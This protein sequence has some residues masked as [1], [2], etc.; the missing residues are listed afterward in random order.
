MSKYKN[1]EGAALI[2]TMF[3]ITILLLFVSA[4]LFQVT[5]TRKQVNTME[6]SIM[7]GHMA[8]MG[9]DYYRSF[10]KNIEQD[11]SEPL[12]K[13]VANLKSA[14][15]KEIKQLVSSSSNGDDRSY[16]IITDN[17]DTEV[18]DNEI[19]IEFTSIGKAYD[20]EKKIESTITISVIEN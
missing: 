1:E 5:N 2:L 16:G 18:T 13:Y 6:K 8:E 14:L 4:Q 7:V 9:V 12:T 10:V 15:N 19:I 20:M 3:I 17:V 11:P